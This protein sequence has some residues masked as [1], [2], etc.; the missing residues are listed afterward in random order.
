MSTRPK[1]P[2]ALQAAAA[3]AANVGG[4]DMLRSSPVPERHATAQ[5]KKSTAWERRLTAAI[6]DVIKR[7]KQVFL[8]L[9]EHDEQ[10]D[11]AAGREA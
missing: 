4:R 1:I 10:R 6:R 3:T 2:I 9:A 11:D 5:M 7:R 8:D